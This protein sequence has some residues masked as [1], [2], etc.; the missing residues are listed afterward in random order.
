MSQPSYHLLLILGTGY[1]EFLIS[2]LLQLFPL[3]IGRRVWRVRRKKTE[4]SRES[5]VGGQKMVAFHYISFDF[6][7]I[8]LDNIYVSFP[9]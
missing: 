3:P 1:V 5:D 6:L 7:S 4:R 9:I 2:C 8:F